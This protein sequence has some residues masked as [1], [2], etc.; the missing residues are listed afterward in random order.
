MNTTF[1]IF[2]KKHLSNIPDIPDDPCIAFYVA[3]VGGPLLVTNVFYVPFSKIRKNE[4]TA[5]MF[6]RR[7][8]DDFCIERKHNNVHTI[9][10]DECT[11]SAAKHA[12]SLRKLVVRLFDKHN[13]DD[14]ITNQPI[15]IFDTCSIVLKREIKKNTKITTS[16][17]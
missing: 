10:L 7:L 9:H 5:I 15:T 13:S 16:N 2:K 12:T 3:H 14:N 1:E 11:K 6:F 17:F 4:K 8:P